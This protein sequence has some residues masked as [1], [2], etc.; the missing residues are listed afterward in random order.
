MKKLISLFLI[1]AICLSLCTMFVSC[2]E[3]ESEDDEQLL[4]TE[5]DWKAKLHSDN[6]K[7][8]TL[9]ISQEVT[10]GDEEETYGVIVKF[11]EGRKSFHT[12]EEDADETH[13]IQVDIDEITKQKGFYEQIFY[14]IVCDFDNF[15]YDEDKDVYKTTKSIAIGGGTALDSIIWPNK[16][17]SY[18][19]KTADKARSVTANRVTVKLDEEGRLYQISATYVDYTA[20]TDKKTGKEIDS[21]SVVYKITWTFSDYGSTI[22]KNSSSENQG[23]M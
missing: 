22:V 11:N 21:F 15:T 13:D 14:N 7:N 19:Y 17:N 3:E 4:L 12:A 9:E 5:E 10:S 2:K 8:Y 1:L 18:M 6:F 20:Y 23:N 16:N